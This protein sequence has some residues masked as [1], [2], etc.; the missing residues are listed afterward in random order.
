MNKPITNFAKSFMA[1]RSPKQ[2]LR[3]AT[4]R[5][6]YNIKLL[7]PYL[8]PKDLKY[9]GSRHAL[10]ELLRFLITKYIHSG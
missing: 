1:K 10:R 3:V 7:A 2:T 8:N 9:R 5:A 4:G 6:A